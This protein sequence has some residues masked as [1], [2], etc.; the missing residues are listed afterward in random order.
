MRFLRV[1]NETFGLLN[2]IKVEKLNTFFYKI[3]SNISDTLVKAN[4]KRNL[5]VLL[6]KNLLEFILIIFLSS[7]IIVN[8]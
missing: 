5:I 6:S 4:L 1:I 2:Y 8:C 3:F 7:A